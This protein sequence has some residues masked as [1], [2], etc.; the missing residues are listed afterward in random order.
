MNPLS[1]GDPCRV[2][3]CSG[4][5]VE[6]VYDYKNALGYKYHY[7]RYQGDMLIAVNR[8]LLH[9][10]EC[11]FVGPSCVLAPVEVSNGQATQN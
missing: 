7:L 5:V 6:A 8:K 9:K 10:W 4:K 2:R 11:R 1:K 3:L